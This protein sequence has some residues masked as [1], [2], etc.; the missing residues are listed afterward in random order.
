MWVMLNDAWFSIVAD[1]DDQ[2][3]LLVRSRQSGAIKRVFGIEEDVDTQADYHFRC[4]IARDHVAGVM[5]R[6]VQRI[7][8]ENFK[9]SVKDPA[10]KTAYNSVWTIG[11][12][13]QWD[14][15]DKGVQRRVLQPTIQS[16]AVDVCSWCQEDIDHSFHA[17]EY[18]QPVDVCES[19][20]RQN[21]KDMLNDWYTNQ[22]E[23][24]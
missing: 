10:L 4:F 8:Y 16:D 12:K 14:A 22:E 1:R 2:E 5:A 3:Y 17:P 15:H 6:E 11:Y 13:M 7:T 20:W 24:E 9:N 23:N 21:G 18:G 19:C